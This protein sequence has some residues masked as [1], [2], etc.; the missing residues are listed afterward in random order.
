MSRLTPVAIYAKGTPVYLLWGR[1]EHEFQGPQDVI[2]RYNDGEFTAWGVQDVGGPTSVVSIL[3]RDNPDIDF[4]YGSMVNF[5]GTGPF[6]QALVGADI[7]AG[8]GSSSGGAPVYE[9]S[10]D[11][12]EPICYMHSSG[13][14]ILP[15]LDIPYFHE[16]M[17][18]NVDF[19]TGLNRLYLGP[20]ELPDDIADTYE[21]VIQET[22]E[23]PEI[24]EWSEEIG[25][26][27][28][29]G[30]RQEAQ[31]LHDQTMQQ[32]PN[33]VDVEELR[34]EFG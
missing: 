24:T 18:V 12:V 30:D 13:S 6:M 10:P 29:F 1:V 8:L 15:D 28:A 19:L 21:Q 34:Q 4:G 20:P 2:D 3:M 32:I 14:A 31:E 5:T 23:E 27:L 33:Q 22:L 16:E 11:V 25:R 9:S 26:P 17:G 7:P